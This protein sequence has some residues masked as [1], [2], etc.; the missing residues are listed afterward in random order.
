MI[1]H[2]VIQVRRDAEGNLLEVL[3]HGAEAEGTLAESVIHAEVARQ[4][5]PER[6]ASSS[7]DNLMRV[8]DEVRAAVTDWQ[9]MRAQA[10]DVVAQLGTDPPPL[11]ARRGHRDAR[12]PDLARGPQLHLPRATASTS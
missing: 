12:V 2:P 8:I 5:D 6:A 1:I 9:A 4:T 10:L 11:D 3:P 7:R